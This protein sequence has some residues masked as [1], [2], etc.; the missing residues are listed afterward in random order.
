MT[1]A[2]NDID[3]VGARTELGF[4]LEIPTKVGCGGTSKM[5][6]LERYSR[7]RCHRFCLDLCQLCGDI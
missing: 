7:N 1:L 4:H 2:S 3:I 6:P 5:P